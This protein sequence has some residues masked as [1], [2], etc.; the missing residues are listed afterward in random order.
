MSQTIDLKNVTIRTF[1]EDILM[2]VI[3]IRNVPDQA[4]I[5]GWLSFY[6]NC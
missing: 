4:G 5:S 2:K 1:D 6:R 3:L